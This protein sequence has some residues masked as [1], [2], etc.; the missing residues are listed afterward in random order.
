MTKNVSD[1]SHFVINLVYFGVPMVI[2]SG[3]AAAISPLSV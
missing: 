1:I 3:F 2:M